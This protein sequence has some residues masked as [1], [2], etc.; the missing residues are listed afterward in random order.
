MTKG[1][2]FVVS[3]P[4]GAGKGTICKEILDQERN[5]EMSV[6]MTTRSPR[7]G[8]IDKVH[9]HF[10]DRESFE[11][12]IEEDGFMEYADV[13]G[14]FYGTPKRKV[15]EWINAG[16]DVILEIDVQ[17]A[18]QIKKNYPE[19]V[20]IFILPP[21]LTE[22]KNR[23]KG[24]GSETEETMARRLGEA[25][26]EIRCIDKYDYRVIN[27]ELDVAIDRVRAIITAEQC[28]INDEEVKRIVDK[29]EEVL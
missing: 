21:S 27:E 5:I 14:N 9:Y 12:L 2:L 7:K 28:K 6:S 18:M 3:G 29:Y 26:N 22:L 13:Y 11:K 4:S 17:G 8:E 1:K 19:G 16:I 20:F 10:V 15:L 24:R 25:L 23:I